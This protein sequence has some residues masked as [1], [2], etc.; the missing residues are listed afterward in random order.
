MTFKRDNALKGRLCDVAWQIYKL[1]SAKH[2]PLDKYSAAALL[3]TQA[4]VSR[5]AFRVMDVWWLGA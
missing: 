5:G 1:A 2:M 3:S 4:R